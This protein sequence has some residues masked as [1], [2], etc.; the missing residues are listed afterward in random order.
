MDA[1]ETP[2]LKKSRFTEFF[3]RENALDESGFQ[4]W[5]FYPGMLFNAM[6]KWWGNRGKRDKPHEGLDL[7]FYKDRKDRIFCFDEKMKIP[8]LYDGIVVK[9]V[10][11]FMGKSVFVE[12]RLPDSNHRRFFMIYGHT[13]PLPHL[14]DGRIVK[15]GEII[16]AL[17]RPGKPQIN[18]PPHLHLSLAWIFN[19]ISYENLNWKTMGNLKELKWVDPL[20]VISRHS[21]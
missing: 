19:K 3:I 11:D 18:I 2:F 12:H 14:H 7:C 4:E 17:A 6:D 9:M 21:L 8:A 1:S 5:T 10:D 15:E 16:A 20:Q 13:N